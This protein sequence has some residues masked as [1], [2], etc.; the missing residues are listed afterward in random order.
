MTNQVH[1]FNSGLQARALTCERHDRLL[2]EN[3]SFSVAP[4]EILHIMG[5]NGVG[6]TSLL[7]LLT[8]LVVP[9]SG[10]VLWHGH[11]IGEDLVRFRSQLFYIGHRFGLSSGLTV[12]ENLS[13]LA[14]LQVNRATIASEQA[15]DKLQ[16]LLYADEKVEHLSMGQRKRV[17]FAALLLASVNLWILDEPYVSLDHVGIE[18]ISCIFEDFVK[19]GGIIVITSHQPLRLGN[20][21]QCVRSVALPC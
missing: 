12:K 9:S 10:A 3:I 4:G 11:S 7:R 13:Y 21:M 5:A 19:M 2:F 6:K 1:S 14:A 17:A 20:T 18:L 8:G 15:L 16:M